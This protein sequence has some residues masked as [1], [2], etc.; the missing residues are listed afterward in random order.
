MDMLYQVK[1]TKCRCRLTGVVTLNLAAILGE[2]LE[3]LTCYGYVVSI[4]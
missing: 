4:F 3:Y 1:K 2:R